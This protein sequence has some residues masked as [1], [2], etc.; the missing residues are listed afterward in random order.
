MSTAA[1]RE[2]LT[3]IATELRRAK[4]WVGGPRSTRLGELADRVEAIASAEGET[5]APAAGAAQTTPAPAASTPAK[6]QDKNQS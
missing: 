5:P 3:S 2:E 1:E 4:T 6:A